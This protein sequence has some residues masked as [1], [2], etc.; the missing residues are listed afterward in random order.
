MTPAEVHECWRTNKDGVGMAW[1]TDGKVHMRKGYMKEDS[2]KDFYQD[3]PEGVQHVVHF[4]TSTAHGVVPELTHPF[5]INADSPNILEHTGEEAVLFH[6]GIWSDWEKQTFQFFLNNG[7]KV[8]AGVWSDSRA[9]AIICDVLGTNALSLITGKFAIVTTEQIYVRGDFEREEGILFSNSGYKSYGAYNKNYYDSEYGYGCAGAKEEKSWT[10][11]WAK[12]K[13]EANRPAGCT[14][15][16][17]KGKAEGA[18]AGT[19]P[20]TNGAS[21]PVGGGGCR[22]SQNLIGMPPCAKLDLSRLNGGGERWPF[23]PLEYGG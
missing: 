14:H 18:C 2:F 11:S 5:L 3:F 21:S 8:P 7:I 12:R 22:G 23:I 15:E 13:E 16:G 4:R 17:G 6:N 10:E 20:H 19:R 1:M 9:L